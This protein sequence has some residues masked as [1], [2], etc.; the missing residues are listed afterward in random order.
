MPDLAFE[1]NIEKFYPIIGPLGVKLRGEIGAEANLAFG[2]DTKGLE[3]SLKSDNSDDIFNGFYIKDQISVDGDKPEFTL[4]AE[5]GAAGE[6][7]IAVASAG[8]EGGIRA[9]AFFNVHDP[10]NDNKIR[11]DEIVTLF[12]D[13]PS[14]LFDTRGKV[15]AGL[16]AYY[17]TL[18]KKR[19]EFGI[20][21]I[22][23]DNFD[24]GCHDTA[25]VILAQEIGGVWQLN[26]GPNAGNRG[27]NP[28]IDTKDGNEAFVVS[29]VD[30]TIYVSGIGLR[31][32]Y[33][34]DSLITANGGLGNDIINI[35]PE[36]TVS[37]ELSGGVGED[38]LYYRGSGTA[39]LSGGP[40]A[41]EILGSQGNDELSGGPGDDRLLGAGGN[42]ILRGGD[43]NDNLVGEEGNDSLF[44]EAGD[45]V[46][47]TYVQNRTRCKVM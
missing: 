15:T 10:N 22:Q 19:K 18:L 13:D 41:D 32:A 33:P 21:E 11:V 46:Q 9:N 8:V 26:M 44:G 47:P 6:I 29:N 5:V 17:E 7:N 12:E 14:C 30:G 25:G 23:L 27:D 20:G 34:I 24:L 2:F 4:T 1:F 43:D 36:I 40:D 3:D 45:G 16:Y 31:K 37:A 39:K 28:D 35:H 42:D 38:K